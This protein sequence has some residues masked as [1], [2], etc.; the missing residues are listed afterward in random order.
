MQVAHAVMH[1]VTNFCEDVM[2]A[3][4]FIDYLQSA[5][6]R[7]ECGPLYFT[8]LFNFIFTEFFILHR[9]QPNL[10]MSC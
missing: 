3:S 5:S 8:R 10:L 9:M 6:T 7:N 2:I 1:F 4:L